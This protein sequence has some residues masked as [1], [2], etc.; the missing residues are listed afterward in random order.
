[1][2]PILNT[3]YK[4]RMA[5][6]LSHLLLLK[7]MFSFITCLILSVVPNLFQLLTSVLIS[8]VSETAVNKGIY[9]DSQQRRATDLQSCSY[10]GEKSGKQNLHG[11][12]LL[13]NNL[14]KWFQRDFMTKTIKCSNTVFYVQVFSIILIKQFLTQTNPTLLSSSPEM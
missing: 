1:M 14:H 7:I 3:M 9:F 6:I 4:K 2:N 8:S 13:C 12:E 10:F 5:H 11:K